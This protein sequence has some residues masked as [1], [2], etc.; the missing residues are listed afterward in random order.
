M[1]DDYPFVECS[2]CGHYVDRDTLDPET[3]QCQ[4]CVEDA[5]E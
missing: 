2:D 5:D 4:E 3:G 1:T